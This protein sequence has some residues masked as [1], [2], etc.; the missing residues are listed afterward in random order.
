MQRYEMFPE[1]ASR[2]SGYGIRE[3]EIPG[4]VQ[5][6]IQRPGIRAPESGIRKSSSED[7]LPLAMVLCSNMFEHRQ[8]LY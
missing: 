1:S 7:T 3:G 8:I 2:N 6:G 4:G 5:P